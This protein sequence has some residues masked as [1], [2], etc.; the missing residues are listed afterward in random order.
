MDANFDKAI[1]FY[2]KT[3]E[4]EPDF[5]Y[6]LILMGQCYF[7]KSMPLESKKYFEEALKF[8]G[9]MTVRESN[10]VR[11]Y[12]NIHSEK[13]LDKAFEAFQEILKDYPD[14]GDANADMG[15]F[16]YCIEE[17]DETIKYC[18]HLWKSEYS[19]TWIPY[20]YLAN[21]YCAKG[22]YDKAKECLE[23]FLE[24]ILEHE[25]IR[26]ALAMVY[27][28]QANYDQAL[29]EIERSPKSDPNF[30]IFY[31][32]GMLMYCREDYEGSEKAFEE[33]TKSNDPTYPA[34]AFEYLHNTL[35]VQ[36]RFK[37]AK[38]LLS[39]GMDYSESNALG[40]LIPRFSLVLLY[41]LIKAGQADEAITAFDELW[42]TANKAGIAT[43]NYKRRLMHLKGM[44][45]LETGDL[46]EAHKCRSALKDLIDS[47]KNRKAMRLFY[48]LAGLIEMQKENMGGALEYFTDAME[49]TPCQFF[50]DDLSNSNNALFLE[51]L[52]RAYYNIGELDKA[53]EQF[54][55]IQSLTLGRFNQGDI[56]AKSYYMLG[57]IFEQKGWQGKAIESYEKFLD[58][59]KNADPGLPEVADARERLAALA[60][61]FK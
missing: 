41:N 22:L 13:T 28:C 34:L 42:E 35:I 46:D 51:S 6:V 36:G 17:W 44:A 3:L 9:R 15:Y 61:A 10:Y 31:A 11:A 38:A 60:G 29:L 23:Y 55:G 24:N 4:L 2:E 37:E 26:M 20:Y 40:M 12:L 58:L 18:G 56:Y 45:L 32:S 47:G 54:E 8:T 33:L 57:K 49:L 52:G 7:N 43:E 53:I 14:E 5:G 48:H 19:L 50:G 39:K 21:A 16:N 59:W 27:L 30:Y 25:V 1:D